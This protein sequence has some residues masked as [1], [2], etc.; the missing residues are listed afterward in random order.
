M[1]ANPT[2]KFLL[3]TALP[4]FAIYLLFRINTFAGV[5]GRAAFILIAVIANRALIY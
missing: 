2:A 3:F 5:I 4:L 1:K